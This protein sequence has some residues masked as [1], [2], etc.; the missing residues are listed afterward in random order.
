M[1]IKKTFRM[2]GVTSSLLLVVLLFSFLMVVITNAVGVEWISNLLTTFKKTSLVIQWLLFIF[3]VIF[4]RNIIEF[5]YKKQE[6]RY[7]LMET[8]NTTVAITFLLL[9]LVSLV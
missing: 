4:Y 8:K 1:N 5:F 3:L 7:K 9:L 2:V 6:T